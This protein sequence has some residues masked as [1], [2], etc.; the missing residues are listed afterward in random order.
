VPS[1]HLPLQQVALCLDCDECFEIRPEMTCPA[2]GSATWTSLSRLLE[3]GRREA[4]LIADVARASSSALELPTVLRSIAEAA[5]DVC[6]ADF[7][8]VAL[9]EEGRDT[10]TVRAWA[11]DRSEEGGCGVRIA[12]G[13]GA[14]GHVLLTGRPFR[15]A[16]YLEGARLDEDTIE[17]TRA[18]RDRAE[19]VVPVR[20]DNHLEGLLYVSRH[21]ARPFTDTDETVLTQLAEHAA[22]AIRNSELF[23][24]ERAARMLA[25]RAHGSLRL[26]FADAPLPMAVYD[27][28]TQQILEVNG[29]ALDHYGYTREEFLRL[30]AEDLIHPDDVPTSVAPSPE[31]YA[32]ETVGVSHSPVVRHVTKARR[33]IE[34]EVLAHPLE[35]AGRAAQLIV[36]ID[37]T[38]RRRAFEELRRSEERFAKVFHTAMVAF[39]MTTL[40]GQLV[41][42]NDHY[43]AMFGYTRAEMVGRRVDDLRL[44]A[45][46][47]DRELALQK[48][49]AP[50]G[51][52]EVEVRLRRRSGEMF[53]ALLSLESTQLADDALLIGLMTDISARKRADEERALLEEQLRQAQKMEA[54][55]RLAGG[56]AHDFNN[57]LA[58]IGGRSQMLLQR[59]SPDDPRR[60]DADTI[61]KAVQRA[62][63]LAQQLLAFSR[64]QVLRPRALAINDVVKDVEPVLRRLV[65]EDI[66]FVTVL[67][68]APGQILADPVQLEQVLLNLSANARDAMPH[69]GRLTIETRL[70]HLDAT[71]VRQHPDVIP[72]SYVALMVTDTGVGMTREVLA[73]IFEPFFTTKELGKG[74][75]LGLATVYGVVK[76]MGGHISAHSEVG[77]GTE[78]KIYLPPADAPPQAAANAPT[79]AAR[80]CETL[81]LVEDEGDVRELAADILDGYGYR[82]LQAAGPAEALALTERHNGPIDLL[83]TDVVMPQMSGPQLARCLVMARPNV[84]VLYM[85][86]Y[87]EHATLQRDVLD[88]EAPLLQKPFTAEQLAGR[89]REALTG[90]TV[91]GEARE[92]EGGDRM[93]S[94]FNEAI[95]RGLH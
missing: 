44:W 79:A 60:R 87:S 32:R 25:E 34:V 66:E 23:A 94:P 24:R 8:R 81:L 18:K 61:G 6:H 70:V 17:A 68:A 9:R 51:V 41:D 43:A 84:R 57:L 69:G 20:V 19:L 90:L 63:G 95:A 14:G 21:G 12:P 86:G 33:T 27:L 73:R 28:E 5:S 56:I 42:C 49:L 3:T 37:V 16:N 4:K 82:V 36:V 46:A 31:V 26:L 67:E 75:G 53:S 11:G 38:E 15:T 72:G 58:V 10:M 88:P 91:A 93:L 30:R 54:I 85:S 59:L 76:Q 83:V 47:A 64:R 1:I 13:R 78:F 45:N 80:G 89:V 77:Q 48:L 35:F 55:G 39:S 40:D 2:C 65:G 52:R 92:A 62:A 29:A 22:I 7:A 50:D 71:Y 74:T